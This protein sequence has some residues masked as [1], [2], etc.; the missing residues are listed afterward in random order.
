MAEKE[1][2]QIKGAIKKKG[3]KWI[4]TETPL[5]K[6]PPD[7]RKKWLGSVPDEPEHEEK[8]D[9]DDA[10]SDVAT[11]SSWDWRNA[12]G[13]HNWTT[14][15]KTQCGCG[16]CVAFGTLGAMECFLKI[17]RNNHVDN[18]DFSEAHLFF[19]NNR[20]CNPGDPRYGWGSSSALNYLKSQGVPDENCFVYSCPANNQAC[21]TCSNWQGRATKITNWKSISSKSGMKNWLS[22]K[23]PLVACYTVYDDFFSY[24]S[25]VYEHVTGDVAGGHCVAVV[26]FNDIDQCWICKNSWGAGWGESGYF[27]IKY[28]QCGIDNSMQAIE[29]IKRQGWQNG[30]KIVGLW[31][32]NENRNAWVLVSGLGWRKLA[33]NH[34]S[35]VVDLMI[36]AAHA[37]AHNRNVNF[38]EDGVEGGTIVIKQMYAW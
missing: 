34:N 15:V 28:G 9:A 26:G 3:A 11:G 2:N 8:A 21:N 19:C 12:K 5:S 6:L 37:K 18:P 14:P 4:A 17:L 13:N 24:S 30:K 23:G 33:N 7:E 36:E 25:G 38:Y 10:E 20:Q 31:A 1:I 32:I 35:V 22:S 16:S 29:G 27:R